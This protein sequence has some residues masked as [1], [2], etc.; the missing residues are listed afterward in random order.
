MSLFDKTAKFLATQTS[1][2]VDALDKATNKVSNLSEQNKEKLFEKPQ[3]KEVLVINQDN[4]SWKDRFDVYNENKEVKYTVKGRLA[5]V[6]RELH[7][8][9]ILGREVG[10]IKK[11]LVSIRQPFS[12][13]SHPFDCII[14]VGGK[15]LGKVR[16]RSSLLKQK[17]E[18]GFNGWQIEGNVLGWT[19]NVYNGNVEIAQ[20]S[21]KLLY[22]GD[23]YVITYSNPENELILLLLVLALDAA[24]APSKSEDLKRSLHNKIWR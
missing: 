11:K 5:S 7:V 20:I 4:Y 16:S 22:F 21:K 18:V 23:T 9:N 12:F 1:V 24:H 6:T 15:T 19:Y 17:Y 8:F 13:D 2:V 10:S 3:G 14:E